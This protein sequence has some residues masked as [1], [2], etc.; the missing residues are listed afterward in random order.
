MQA[1]R[2]EIAGWI[3]IVALLLSS[4]PVSRGETPKLAPEKQT[5]LDTAASLDAQ[6][7]S[8]AHSL[9]EY[10]ETGI[11]VLTDSD[12]LE[13]A[14]ADFAEKTRDAPYR[15]P[16]PPGQEPPLPARQP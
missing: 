5:V 6:I 11:D 4:A 9:W 7:D 8:M 1:N 14:R 15:S 2:A 16:I 13:R 3:T 10:A 12:L